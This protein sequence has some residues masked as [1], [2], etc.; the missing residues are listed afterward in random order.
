MKGKGGGHTKPE[1]KSYREDGDPA[2]KAVIMAGGRGA[3]LRPLTLGLPKPMLPVLGRPLMEHTIALLK[4]HGITQICVTLCDR[5]QRAMDYFGDGAGLGVSL[6][7]FIEE[8]PLGTAG[9]VKNCARWLGGEDFLVVS[10]DCLCDLDLRR[11][12]SFHRERGA[13]ATLALCRGVSPLEFGLVTTRP[14]GRVERFVEKPAWGQV[15]TDLVNTGIYLLSPSVLE[16]IPEGKPWD[17]GRDLFPTLVRAGA[18]VFGCLLEGYWR[19]VGDCGSY[20][21]C[22]CDALSGKVKVDPGLP[23]RAPGVWSSAPVPDGVSLIPPCWIGPEV[24]LGKGSLIGPHTILEQGAWVGE[25]A[26]LQRSVLLEG[27]GAGPRSTL[28]GAVL[29]PGSA[30][31]RGAV[32]NEGAVLGENALAEEGSQLM[33]GVKI[34]PGQAARAGCRLERS[35]TCGS[36]KGALRFGEW[37]AIPGVVGEDL[38]PEGLLA[39]GSVLGLEGRVGLGCSQTPSARMLAQAAQAGV[40][41]SGGQAVLCP[42]LESPVQWADAVEQAGLAVSLFI[43]EGE[44][45]VY[46]HLLDWQG[47]PFDREQERRLEHALALGEVHRV[48]AGRIK[49]TEALSLTVE[50]WAA[51]TARRASLNRPALRK[52][53]AAVEKDTPENRALRAALSALG[54][55]L[56]VHWR[57][58]IPAFSAGHGGFSLSA[59]DERGTLLEGGQLLALVTL[60]EMENGGGK[61]AVPAEGSAAVDLVAAGYRGT[62]LRLDRD[63]AQARELYASLPWLWSAPSAAVR[64]CA[65]MGVSGQKLETLMSKTPRFSVWKRE[66]PLTA[67]RGAVMRA[68]AGD[69]AWPEPGEGLRLRTGSGWVY[70]APMARRHALRVMA[71]GPD[72]ELAAEL[73]DFYAARAMQLDRELGEE[74]K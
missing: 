65:R 53:T 19:D 64:I 44:G 5:P 69:R 8:E 29:C 72:L 12:A 46:L 10:G 35:V 14:D 38:G 73:C 41:A 34:W 26:L 16:E 2:V 42:C 3:R 18:P 68:L 1:S 25:R 74:E 70:L 27:A 13:A 4:G 43:Q 32:L 57:P 59:Q 36:Q 67:H 40:A 17:F 47:L 62:V 60:I 7:Y 56:E 21:D 11:L 22:L 15:V 9:S 52:I 63:G 61:V 37:G 6:T 55:Q 48:R 23:L 33:E 20:L 24:E 30:A 66:V 71:E 28:Y 49:E 54:C 58:G 39:L 31:R 45:P 50:S 51:E